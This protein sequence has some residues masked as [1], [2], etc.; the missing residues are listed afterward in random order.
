MVAEALKELDTRKG[1]S[2]PAIR[3]HILSSY[4]TVDPARLKPLLR[5]ALANG[6]DNGTLTRPV[7]SIATGAT[8][9][10]KVRTVCEVPGLYYR[11]L[12]RA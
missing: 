1:T 12:H 5:N 3:S 2:V 7:N 6:I 10:F 8:G 11:L 4:P 9:R